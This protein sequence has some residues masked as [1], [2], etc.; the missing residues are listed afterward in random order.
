MQCEYII[1]EC[2]G[3]HNPVNKKIGINP[4]PTVRSDL[5]RTPPRS[6]IS[7]LVFDAEATFLLV[8]LE[9][10]PCVVHV[11]NFL[12]TPG[13]SSPDIAHLASLVFTDVVRTARWC[14]GRRKVAITTKSG[15]VYFWDGDGG[16]VE[17]GDES[18]EAKGGVAEGVGIPTRT[19]ILPVWLDYKANY[20]DRFHCD[21]S[22]MVA[23]RQLALHS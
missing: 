3:T 18:G 22:D 6:G 15:G 16:W 20:S 13:S 4:L 9:T 10:Q 21:R 23:R 5:T 17:D 1:Y 14:S 7:H 19:F 8:R 12:P 2:A 11:Y